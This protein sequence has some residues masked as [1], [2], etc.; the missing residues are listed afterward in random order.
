MWVE[1]SIALVFGWLLSYFVPCREAIRTIYRHLFKGVVSV[2]G[3]N[4]IIEKE[5]TK[6]VNNMGDGLKMP[7]FENHTTIPEVGYSKDKMLELLNKHFTH[8][9]KHVSTKMISG[10]FYNGSQERR[11]VTSE[12][13][14]LFILA[15]PLHAENCPSVRKMEAEVIRMTANMLH[16]DSETA[17]LVTTGGSESIVLAVRAH[18]QNAIKKG[19][20]P[21]T[22]EIL[23]SE[24]AHPAW[25]K[26]CDLMHIKPVLVPLDSK[27]SLNVDDVQKMYTKNTILIVTSAPSYPHGVIDDITAIATFGKHVGI[28]IHVDACLGGFVEA[29]GKEAGYNVPDFD[30]SVDGVMSISCDTHKYAY[31]P[32]G[33]SVLLY[34]SHQLRDLTFFVFPKW[35]GGV[36]CSPSIPGSRAGSSIAGAWAA[37]LYTGRNG[38]VKATQAIL[39]TARKIKEELVKLDNVQLLCRLEQDTSVVSFRTTDVNIY[40]VADCMSKE[41]HW[42]FNSL[43]KPDAVHFC[44]T[45]RTAG[46]EEK[47]MTDLLKSI[48]IIR[49]DPKSKKYN[50]WAPVYGM[51]SSIPDNA[52]LDDMVG[53]V[54]ALYCDYI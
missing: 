16:G 40:K 37:L 3:I 50:V 2:T 51:T 25:L 42:E 32:K 22:C 38:Y 31:A 11:E 48:D 49:K 36:Y 18:Y 17:G 5:V 4:K 12:A 13:T 46:C 24:N 10:S 8:D 7:D 43:Q 28:P 47:F 52:I 26:G 9:E 45:E 20:N 15:N 1:L 29:W 39:S 35:V 54:C 14:K 44:L 34:K 19:F 41:F 33:T 21:L 23:M 53:Q 27:Y 6:A 30:F